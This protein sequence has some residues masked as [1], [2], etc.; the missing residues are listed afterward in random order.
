MAHDLVL[1]DRIRAVLTDTRGI[2]ETNMFGGL[3][4]MHLGNMLCGADTKYG[5]MVRIGPEAYEKTLKLKYAKP[6]AITGK[7]MRGFIFV[8]KAGYTTSAT[9]KKWVGKGLLFTSALP[10]KIR[11]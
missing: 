5:L 7:P 2:T 10:K 3:M 11:K 9:L 8:D 6:M 4:F 1:N